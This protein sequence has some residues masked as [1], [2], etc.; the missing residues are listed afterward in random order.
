MSTETN[1]K[2][3]IQHPTDSNGRKKTLPKNRSCPSL[4]A[5]MN[6]EI[7]PKENERRNVPANAY[8]TDR[9]FT[10]RGKDD[11]KSSSKL[12]DA[13]EDVYETVSSSTL[14]AVQDLRILPLKPQQDSVY[15]DKHCLRPS[16]TTHM[17]SQHPPQPPQYLPKHTSAL[18]ARNM[19]NVKGEGVKKYGLQK[20]LPPPRP[21]KT[22]PKQY[23]PLPPEPKISSHV[24]HTRETP[25]QSHI[26]P[27]SAK[28]TRH[29]SFRDLSEASG[30]DKD[31]RKKLELIL[32]EQCKAK[33]L[34]EASFQHAQNSKNICSSGSMVDT[35]NA[36]VKRSPSPIHHTTCENKPKHSLA[37]EKMEHIAQPIEKDLH[38]Y[39]W[40]IGEC[41]RHEAEAALLEENTDETFLVRDCSKKSNTEPYVLVVYYGR[42]V[43]NI[44]V[45]FLEDSQQYALGTGLR[46][47]DKFNSV[48][49]IIDFYKYVP[50]TLIDGKDKTGIQRVQCYL[51]HPLRLHKMYP[52][53]TSPTFE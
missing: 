23:H 24:L 17:S 33:H 50:I 30:R 15:A 25:S 48:K 32:Q 39:E 46:G 19:S 38:K 42:R 11:L 37:K 43:Y 5:E 9:H 29:L 21:L 4:F 52:T 3:T 53:L 51:T 28:P 10:K 20:P 45:R 35:D 14:E 49:D 12:S 8:C 16:G 6:L 26:F 1:R 2:T 36:S 27:V 18:E 31:K 7:H 34:P 13:D 40:Y 44:K 41:D 47:D 22:L